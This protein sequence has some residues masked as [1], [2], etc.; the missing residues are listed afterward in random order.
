MTGKVELIPVTVASA[1]VFGMVLAL[2]G[3]I[4]LALANRLDINETRV[5]G[6]LS[7]LSL[8]LIPMM[9][10]SGV[11]IDTFGVKVLLFFGSVVLALA[12]FGLAMSRTYWHCLVS[13]L[14]IGAAGP[15]ISTGGVVLMGPAF[16]PENQPAAQ[17][18]G[19]VFFG[20]GALVTP[21]LVALML[22]GL[23]FRKT[24]GLLALICLAPAVTD[25]LTD[26]ALFPLPKY[27]A[28]GEVVRQPMLWLTAL[29]F[30]LYCPLEG[31]L[32]TW[33]TTYLTNLGYREGRAALLLSGFWL[34]FLVARLLAAFL[35]LRILPESTAPWVICVLALS[36]AMALGN[37]AGASR[38]GNAA[39]GLLLVGFLFGPI[40]PTLV[41]ILFNHFPQDQHGTAFGAMFALGAMG[42]L[43]LPPM[44][45]AYARRTTVQRAL[46]IPL[47]VALLLAG[48]S[49]FLGLTP[50]K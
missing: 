23:G 30:F 50:W 40:F 48:V 14:L 27:S 20:L 41:G 5:G 44:I 15:C 49:F 12:M 25:A 28:L 16:F 37:L 13:I 36:A 45:G 31:A 8:A 43:L 21:A 47:V 4:K 2:L 24:L 34:S 29:V 3:S 18:L 38:Q 46:R 11:L 9:L 26:S 22:R 7:M 35:E 32:G 42:N 6:L 1:F 33:A 17:N 19:N 10:L 39:W